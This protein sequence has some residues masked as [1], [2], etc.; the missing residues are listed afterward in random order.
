M[1]VERVQD[2]NVFDT[3]SLHP[4][5][6]SFDCKLK[7]RIIMQPRVFEF[8]PTASCST[9]LLKDYTRTFRSATPI[10]A[11]MKECSSLKCLILFPL[12][13]DKT[14]LL[15]TTH[16]K[17]RVQQLI[18]QSHC[19]HHPADNCTDGCEK[20]NKPLSIIFDDFDVKRRDFVEEPHSGK[21][22]SGK[23]VN[24]ASDVQNDE[25]QIE[26]NRIETNRNIF[27]VHMLHKRFHDSRLQETAR[28]SPASGTDVP[29]VLGDAV[30]IRLD[31]R[32]VL[33][34]H[35]RR[36]DLNHEIF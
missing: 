22:C 34:F 4:L 26:T 2:I 31:A 15:R 10:T 5:A 36:H 21:T 11:P 20:A 29:Q 6:S 27:Y 23:M 13:L 3:F 30:L 32:P 17:L 12:L 7:L 9:I 33:E 14:L 28:T 25:S 35:Q 8:I 16:T 19:R 18:Q 24:R 1:K